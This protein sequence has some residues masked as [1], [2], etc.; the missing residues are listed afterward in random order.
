MTDPSP[1]LRFTTPHGVVHVVER[2]QLLQCE[3]WKQAFASSRKDHRY[4]EIVEDTIKQGF[5]YR[6]VICED[7]S[8]QV[9]AIQP[10]FLLDQD[11]LQG[12]GALAQKWAG[13]L[14]K[15]FPRALTIRT[16]MVGC[17][18]GE[19]HLDQRRRTMRPGSP[20]A[21]NEALVNTRGK[22]GRK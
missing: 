1:Q 13:R 5:D 18:A 15:W 11:L 6:Y 16:L 19:G 9:R 3:P 4:Y 21:C 10:A 7:L 8:G 22:C 17:A 14:R 20:A 12:S 2:E